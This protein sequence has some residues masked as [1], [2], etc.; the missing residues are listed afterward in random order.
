MI[1]TRLGDRIARLTVVLV[2]LA[3]VTA[4]GLWWIF[5]GDGSKRVTAY[6]IRA[7]GVYAGSDVRVL[8][9]RVG[10][11]ESVTPRGAEVEVVLRVAGDVPVAATTGAVVIAPSVVAD[12]YV[13]LS[14]LSRGGPRI[15]DGAIIPAARTAT[16][17]ELDELYASLNDIAVALGPDGANAGGAL[18]ELLDVGAANLA[19]NGR[20]ISDTL[21]D[22]ADLS[23]TLGENRDDLFG[24]IDELSRFTAML[25]GNDSQVARVNQQLASVWRTLAADREELAAALDTLGRALGEVQAFVRDHRELIRS[26]VDKL[27][28]TTQALVDQRGSLAE[29][30]DTIPL[31]GSNVLNAFDPESRTLQGRTLID[32]FMDPDEACP[33]PLV[34]TGTCPPDG[35][36]PN[37][38]PAPSAP[39]APPLPLPAAGPVVATE[40]GSR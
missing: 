23:R 3:L 20:A 35:T 6:F 5:S 40:G 38:A 4:A 18:S 2:V 29:A 9:V 22:F 24:T 37:A 12:R 15:A 25:A 32:Y 11:V 7:V 19:G 13:Q 30:L 8:G 31:A 28:G 21:R 39:S 16:P 34:T 1:D 26:N 36:E 33:V 14:E 17:V 27:A 10:E